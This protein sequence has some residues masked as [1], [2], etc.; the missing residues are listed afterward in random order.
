MV[1]AGW[2]VAVAG[3]NQL[4]AKMSSLIATWFKR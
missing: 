1:F 3:I 4:G 2:L